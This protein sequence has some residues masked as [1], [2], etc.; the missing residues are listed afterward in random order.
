MKRTGTGGKVCEQ[1]GCGACTACTACTGTEFG[2]L[3]NHGEGVQFL[4]FNVENEAVRGGCVKHI[5]PLRKL[6]G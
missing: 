6:P 3:A 1:P 2:D 5:K 4:N